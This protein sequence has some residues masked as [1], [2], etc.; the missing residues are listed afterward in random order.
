MPTLRVAALLLCTATTV[1]SAQKLS[2]TITCSPTSADT[3]SAG[4][5][6]GHVIAFTKSSCTW[7]TPAML[8]SAKATSS[9]Q[10][11]V[12][13]IRG[14]TQNIHGYNTTTYDNGDKVTATFQA[15]GTL[16]PD[17]SSTFT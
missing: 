2:G 7:P 5:M 1:M 17:G 12:G 11:G 16:N 14:S 15:K 13:E 6:P 9:T 10:I 4:D 3:A 8:G